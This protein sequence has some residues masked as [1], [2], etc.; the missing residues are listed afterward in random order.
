MVF[1]KIVSVISSQDL[2]KMFRDMVHYQDNPNFAFDIKILHD[3]ERYF[4]FV[5][6]GLFELLL[7]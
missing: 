4:K 7:L 3:M 2:T 6:P 1:F 5:S